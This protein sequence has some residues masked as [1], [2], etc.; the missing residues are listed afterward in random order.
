[1]AYVTEMSA[2]GKYADTQERYLRSPD[3]YDFTIAL[4]NPDLDLL[5]INEDE[6]VRIVVRLNK[7]GQFEDMLMQHISGK[8]YTQVCL[9]DQQKLAAIAI[10]DRFDLDTIVLSRNVDSML[11]TLSQQQYPHEILLFDC[12]FFDPIA[13]VYDGYRASVFC[14]QQKMLSMSM[15]CIHN[16]YHN[17]SICEDINDPLAETLLVKY[18]TM[19]AN[20][21]LPSGLLSDMIESV[22]GKYRSEFVDQVR[23]MSEQTEMPIAP[24]LYAYDHDTVSG[25]FDDIQSNLEKIM[26]LVKLADK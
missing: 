21:G 14:N 8:N 18:K 9:S 19:D 23:D 12:D 3:G 2:Y 16:R 22:F 10:I 15:D 1:M 20:A 11:C 24:L 7:H 4:E 13:A 5:Q 17:W 26:D 25:R 6:S